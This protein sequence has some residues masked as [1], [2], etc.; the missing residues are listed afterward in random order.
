SGCVMMRKCHLNTCPAGIATQD[1]V[2]R[3]KFAGKPEYLVNF[4]FLLAEEVRR[5]MAELGFRRFEEMVGRIDRLEMREAIEHWKARGLE[6]SSI[7]YNPI[8]PQRCARRKVREQDHGLERA[9]DNK[10]IEMAR[11]ALEGHGGVEIRMP[12]RNVHRA[13]GAMLGGEISR[14]CGSRG[15]PDG[16]IRCHF[17]G[18]GGQSFG[19]FAVNGMELTLEGDANDYVGKGISGGRLVIYPPR[20][21][22]FAPEENIIIGNTC[23]YGATGGE[24]YVNGKAGERFAVRNSGATAVVEGLGDHGCEYMTRGVVAVLGKT[25]RNFGAGM[26]GGIAFVLDEVGDFRRRRVNPAMVEVEPVAEGEDQELL[27]EL[28]GKHLHYTRSPRADFLLRHWEQA[29]PSFVKVMPHEYRRVLASRIADFGLRISNE[30]SVKPAV[31]VAA[32]QSAI[33]NPQSEIAK[34]A[35]DG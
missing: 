17:S 31:A 35:A 19:A 25:G 11:P 23:L 2:L 5:L 9:L 8:V 32:A 16:S 6:F 15:L 33:R 20:D 1:P 30:P 7:L 29:L 21:S 22:T 14:R 28:I 27:R 4:F 18:S 26:S 10:L 24:V 3:K 34:G 13:V 12:I